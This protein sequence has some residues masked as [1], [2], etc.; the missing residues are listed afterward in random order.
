MYFIYI[1]YDCTLPSQSYRET[2]A[3]Q[4]PLDLLAPLEIQEMWDLRETMEILACL[5][6]PS[7]DIA[8]CSYI[9]RVVTVV[10]IY[11]TVVEEMS[12]L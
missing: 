2:L 11:S 10:G 1:L 4:A 9:A 7:V 5:G 8:T 12:L 3:S 6:P